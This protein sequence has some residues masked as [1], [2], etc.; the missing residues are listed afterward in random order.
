MDRSASRVF[1][2]HQLLARGAPIPSNVSF[3][4]SQHPLAHSRSYDR[5]FIRAMVITAYS[6]WAAYGAVAILLPSQPSSN[7][8]LTTLASLSVLVV[9]WALFAIQKFPVSFYLYIAFPCY[10]WHQVLVKAASP[11]LNW[12]RS[13]RTRSDNILKTFARAILVGVALQ[14]MVVSLYS[15]HPSTCQYFTRPPIPTATSGVSLS[16]SLG[17]FGPCPNGP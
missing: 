4:Y 2:A 7:V 10:F 17:S 13:T 11:S 6:G 9:S 3:T 1:A 12:L 14:S 5:K 16:S 15:Y 8:L